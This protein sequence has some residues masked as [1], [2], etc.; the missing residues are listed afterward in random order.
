VVA[1]AVIA[2][3]VGAVVL[4]RGRGGGPR[5]LVVLAEDR[6]GGTA[7]LYLAH[8]GDDPADLEPFARGV[9]LAPIGRAQ[10]PGASARVAVPG[11]AVPYR[12][13]AIVAWNDD[14]RTEVDLVRPDEDPERLFR[15][16]GYA[17]VT[18][19]EAGTHLLVSETSG[20]G[21]S[22][23]CSVA[24]LGEEP[25]V[26]SRGASC[27]FAYPDRV[28]E[29][30]T[31]TDDGG[32]QVTVYGID[33]KQR[34]SFSTEGWS[35][36]SPEGDQAAF[37]GDGALEVY[38]LDDGKRLVSVDGD[39]ISTAGWSASGHTLVYERQGDDRA[40]VGVI[41]DGKDR[42]IVAEGHEVRGKSTP[43]GS[44]VITG[45]RD[46]DGATTVARVPASGGR[47]TT[48]VEGDGLG[49]DLIPAARPR[50]V[51][52]GDGELRMGD[53]AKGTP[54]E[55][56]RLDV[57][58]GP[59]NLTYDGSTDTAYLDV[60]DG[61]ERALYRVADGK[62]RRLGDGYANLTVVAAERGRVVATVGDDSD[63]TLL[64]FVD[65][66]E[67]EI[68][69]GWSF[70]QVRI[71]G[72][73]VSYDLAADQ[74]DPTDVER[75]RAAIDGDG[76][77]EVVWQ[78]RSEVASTEGHDEAWRTYGDDSWFASAGSCTDLPDLSNDSTSGTLTSGSVTVC[79]VVPP[80]ETEVDITATSDFDTT[81]SVY[82][83]DGNLVTSADD[84][85]GSDPAISESF[86]PGVYTA[87]LALFTPSESEYSPSYDL[88]ISVYAMGD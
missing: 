45:V 81:L 30:A 4:L 73:E 43:D 86:E 71:E 62:L 77:P 46:E 31:E 12:G 63:T 52:W 51:V 10:G 70:G 68:D 32:T 80:D 2:A 39:R 88:S 26:V 87:E 16:H 3:A 67:H 37:V 72:D 78:E 74:D 50:L 9:S 53:A 36:V 17:T 40:E 64:G 84:T 27:Q 58:D 55:V 11:G 49:F 23:T 54:A 34:S 66:E 19:D 15:T 42:G 60:A 24:A 8:R 21:E 29:T 79:F 6:N 14:D 82:D 22:T 7:D 41:H 38:S 61:D 59:P 57:G 65:G 28:I 25:E 1:V 13:G 83:A 44:A 33:G 85:N 48:L 20:D 69:D 35:D 18:L 5:E 75:R 76:K 47:A 56:G